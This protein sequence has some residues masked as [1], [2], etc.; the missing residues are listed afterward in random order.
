[1]INAAMPSAIARS[2]S[3]VERIL[4]ARGESD[5]GVRGVVTVAGRLGLEGS[6]T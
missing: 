5:P 3:H 4:V 1:M 6:V 2:R